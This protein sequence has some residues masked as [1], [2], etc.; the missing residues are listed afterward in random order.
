M[1]EANECQTNLLKLDFHL[2]D[3]E[4]WPRAVSLNKCVISSVKIY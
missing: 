3:F 1:T 4:I 2:Y